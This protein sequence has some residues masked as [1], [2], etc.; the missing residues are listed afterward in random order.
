MP[1]QRLANVL[2]RRARI[3]G[4]ERFRPHSHALAAIAALAGLL[5]DERLLDRMQLLLGAQAFDRLPGALHRG[6]RR[7]AR[8]DGLA[9]DQHGA[10]AA[11]RKAAAELRP[12]ELE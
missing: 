3:A 4:E 7:A 1:V 2:V 12:V 5:L 8:A 10:G 9:V 6:D 11:L